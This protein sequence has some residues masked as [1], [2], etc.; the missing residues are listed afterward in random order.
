MQKCQIIFL[1]SG[2]PLSCFKLGR[3]RKSPKF[4]VILNNS[5]SY[6]G[7]SWGLPAAIILPRCT[8]KHAVSYKMVIS[9]PAAQFKM[10]AIKSTYLLGETFL[11]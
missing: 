10:I 1:L 9:L 4:I 7:W 3:S 11:Q 2:D 6:C 8:L 5:S